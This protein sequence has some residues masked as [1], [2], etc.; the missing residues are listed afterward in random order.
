MTE[1]LADRFDGGSMQDIG[2][3]PEPASAD[4]ASCHAGRDAMRQA[5]AR[6]GS[7]DVI[8][9]LAADYPLGP[10]DQPQSMCPALRFAPRGPQDAPHRDGAVGFGLAAST[11]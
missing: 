1:S 6:A 3:A 9:R 4:G 8:D 11:A 5:A 7:S 10:H 2:T